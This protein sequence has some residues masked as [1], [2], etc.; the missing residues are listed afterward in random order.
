MV[1]TTDDETPRSPSPE[2]VNC[3]SSKFM[4]KSIPVAD[5]R[6]AD[7][8]H[9]IKP[10][11]QEKAVLDTYHMNNQY[12]S[13]S[14]RTEPVEIPT[15]RSLPPDVQAI[16]DIFHKEDRD[17][18]SSFFVHDHRHGDP[19]MGPFNGS[20]IP[21]KNN[22]MLQSGP[23]PT[24]PPTRFA[25]SRF[26]A[27]N[28]AMSSIH[29]PE[30]VMRGNQQQFYP[31]GNPHGPPHGYPHGYPHGHPH[32]HPQPHGHPHGHW[33]EGYSGN[34]FP[35][36]QYQSR[37]RHHSFDPQRDRY[38][39]DAPTNQR[40]IDEYS[41]GYGG[42]DGRNVRNPWF[43]NDGP[44][45]NNFCTPSGPTQLNVHQ[46][47]PS[48]PMMP[49]RVMDAFSNSLPV[50]DGRGVFRNDNI[51]LPPHPQPE[52]SQRSDREKIAVNKPMHPTGNWSGRDAPSRVLTA[53][54]DSSGMGKTTP[55][56]GPRP[57]FESGH[58]S[59]SY[60]SNPSRSPATANYSPSRSPF[61]PQKPPVNSPTSSTRRED[62]R[63]SGR[64]KQVSS[65]PPQ[66]DSVKFNRPK[67]PREQRTPTNRDTDSEAEKDAAS[68]AATSEGTSGG[69]KNTEEFASPLGGLYNENYSKVGQTGRGYGVQNYRIPKKKGLGPTKS[70]NPKR[71]T[72][73]D[74]QASSSVASPSVA[75]PSVVSSSVACHSDLDPSASENDDNANDREPESTTDGDSGVNGSS[76]EENVSSKPTKNVTDELPLSLDVLENVL[77]KA[78]PS[79]AAEKVLKKVR[80]L[81][82][83]KVEAIKSSNDQSKSDPVAPTSSAATYVARRSLVIYDS[84]SD[85]GKT[86]APCDDVQPVCI[87]LEES[88][89]KTGSSSSPEEAAVGLEK[90]DATPS[91][92]PEEAAVGLEREDA[93]PSEAPEE[94]TVGLEKED[95]TPSGAPEEAAVGL[96]KEDTTPSESV[97]VAESCDQQVGS[98]STEL[99]VTIP[100]E[101]DAVPAS[102][103]EATPVPTPDN[104]VT[105]TAKKRGRKKNTTFMMEVARLQENVV[106]FFKNG[107]SLG[108][109]RSRAVRQVEDNTDALEAESSE[110][111]ATATPAVKRR[112]GRPKTKVRP[113]VAPSTPALNQDSGP[114]AV[115][116]TS[117]EGVAD[118]DVPIE[119]RP[120][121]IPNND[122]DE[123]VPNK[124]E[125]EDAPK[126]L[127]EVASKPQGKPVGRRRRKKKVNAANKARM[128]AKVGSDSQERAAV[129]GAKKMA[130][131]RKIFAPSH[132]SLRGRPSMYESDGSG[133]ADQSEIPCSGDKYFQCKECEFLGQKIVHHYVNEHHGVEIP[134]ISVPE[135]EREAIFSQCPV[136]DPPTH[137]VDRDLLV[138]ISWIPSRPS[139]FNPA[140]C[141]MCSF[142]S[143]MRS[144]LLEHVMVHALPTDVKYR[145][146]L[147][148]VVES[149]FFEMFDHVATHT[150]EYRYQCKYCNYRVARRSCIKQHMS[151]LH[152]SQDI[153]F[154]STH[155][156]AV[157]QLWIYGFVCLTCHFV[158]MDQSHLDRHL[159]SSTCC[160][161]FAK[162]NLATAIPKVTADDDLLNNFGS[163]CAVVNEP[164]VFVCP[165]LDTTCSGQQNSLKKVDE[166]A[167]TFKPSSVSLIKRL[168]EKLCEEIDSPPIVKTEPD[169]L[170]NVAASEKDK[171][172][173]ADIVEKRSQQVVESDS[174]GPSIDSTVNEKDRI[175]DAG[176]VK[177]IDGCAT[178]GQEDSSNSIVESG[179]AT[180]VGAENIDCESYS[181]NL[182]ETWKKP[183]SFLETTIS[184]LVDKLGS[185]AV[186]EGLEDDTFPPSPSYSSSASYEYEESDSCTDEEMD[187]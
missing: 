111:D 34:S 110:V 95:A 33:S 169:E 40:K 112:R 150:G 141:K 90:E 133:V 159:L 108:K 39:P 96:E 73:A 2:G 122:P 65:T 54:C 48:E 67:D 59:N 6:M 19:R 21:A 9:R 156:P 162:I 134:Y 127:V 165:S 52:W 172:K 70:K 173:S 75:S 97:V 106:D 184:R 135:S 170:V 55:K 130:K 17:Y 11:H 137:Q 72:P 100:L 143:P 92:A 129:A 61:L 93:T 94:A 14:L 115:E 180:S 53:E 168:A 83:S 120:E 104:A 116:S 18:R 139:F 105:T 82:L 3:L 126:S 51:P 29:R 28:E 177:E 31:H 20:D 85:D 171:S 8:D 66:Q 1:A 99:D 25:D 5:V 109:R 35:G 26:H 98:V 58:S 167:K 7:S 38:Y 87:D 121:E 102:T 154:Y 68:K 145:C 186:P 89:S 103:N 76:T 118:E 78:L 45:Y 131:K 15:L 147:C 107:E 142:S 88:I 60:N 163:G 13:R 86:D 16:S 164:G 27:A 50:P 161:G 146:A 125:A 62:P 4:P 182:V 132:I 63:L 185:V 37:D 69:S 79:H 41:Y 187:E 71:S 114:T 160:K 77:K 113:I 117:A 157:D 23:T 123:D 155:L 56:Q 174:S 128:N 84:D 32:G 153:L 44:Y 119:E 176:N 149:G 24:G 179:D 136:A 158:Q 183:N 10:Y 144:E 138:D 80:Q 124:E 64:Q 30:D 57:S 166:L 148:G 36:M 46:R 140:S 12:E 47:N 22:E 101:N 42:D 43:H 49:P 81:D 152:E 181:L 175:S 74:D 91:E 178:A 151:S